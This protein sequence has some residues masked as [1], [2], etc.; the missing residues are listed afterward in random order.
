MPLN[1]QP[2][3][4][5]YYVPKNGGRW[6]YALSFTVLTGVILVALASSEH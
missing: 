6:L 1:D 4:E 2:M 5:D 3:G